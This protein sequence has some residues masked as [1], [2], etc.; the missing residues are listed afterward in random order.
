MDVVSLSKFEFQL[1]MVMCCGAIMVP[2]PHTTAHGSFGAG[3]G[4]CV[5]VRGAGISSIGSIV[6]YAAAAAAS[7]STNMFCLGLLP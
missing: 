2:R 3:P 1:K 6:G 4:V 5:C 7:K